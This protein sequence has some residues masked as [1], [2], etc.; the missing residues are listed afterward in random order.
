MDLFDQ[1]VDAEVELMATN[2][3][4]NNSTQFARYTFFGILA[5][6]FAVAAHAR[7]NA[8]ARKFELADLQK[9][10]NVSGP[11]ISPDA[12]SIVIVVSRVNW[13]EDRYDSQLVLVDIAPGAQRSLTTIR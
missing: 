9:I 5:A 12:K 2:S 13:D 10:V 7:A 11:E 6:L 4:L 8:Q 3:N 1:N